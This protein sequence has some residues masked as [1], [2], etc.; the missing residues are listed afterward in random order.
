MALT[1][2]PCCLA[3]LSLCFRPLISI[4]VQAWPDAVNSSSAR[5]HAVPTVPPGFVSRMQNCVVTGATFNDVSSAGSATV[6]GLTLT[7]Q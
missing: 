7:S 5:N 2:A 4:N 6:A 1:L 3:A